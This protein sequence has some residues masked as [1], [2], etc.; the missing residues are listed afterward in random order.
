MVRRLDVVEWDPEPHTHLILHYLD[1]ERAIE[2]E[3]LQRARSTGWA[4]RLAAEPWYTALP[5]T[6]H[7]RN[8]R[9]LKSG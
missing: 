6:Y 2:G 8:R 3:A 9:F 1:H 5:I 4:R 7:R